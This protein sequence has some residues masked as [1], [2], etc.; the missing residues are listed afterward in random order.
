MIYWPLKDPNRT[1]K[2]YYY[3][4]EDNFLNAEECQFLIRFGKSLPMQ[5]GVVSVA[6]NN[7]DYVV[8]ESIRKAN[9]SWLEPSP[10]TEWIYKK[11]QS[12]IEHVNSNYFNLDLEFLEA[13]QFS[14]YTEDQSFF[15]KHLDVNTK[16]VSNCIRKLSFTVQLSEEHS[17][18]GGDLITHSNSSGN[19]MTRTQGSIIFFPSHILHE[20][21]PVTQGTRHSL[22]GWVY[23][24]PLR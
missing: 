20:V 2:N 7:D 3:K 11:V 22:V 9:I 21:T 15:G 8:D 13:L 14:E 24:K 10:Q 5:Q 1:I 19:I 12:S 17:Y 6:Y 23:G 18:T 16:M 4:C